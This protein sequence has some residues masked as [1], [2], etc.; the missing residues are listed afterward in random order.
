M[1]NKNNGN[2]REK[3]DRVEGMGAIYEDTGPTINTRK[4]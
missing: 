3:V 4:L 2:G 1:K